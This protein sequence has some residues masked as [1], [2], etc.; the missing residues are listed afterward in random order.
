MVISSISMGPHELWIVS[1]SQLPNK[2]MGLRNDPHICEKRTRNLLKLQQNQGIYRDCLVVACFRL[3]NEGNPTV[4]AG[5]QFSGAGDLPLFGVRVDH[6]FDKHLLFPGN[7]Q[8]ILV[9]IPH[10]VASG[11]GWQFDI[12]ADDVDVL[13]Y[14]TEGVVKYTVCLK[15]ERME[16][17]ELREPLLD[18]FQFKQRL[19]TGE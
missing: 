4:L 8:E 19:A 18:S 6:D 1:E 9:M 7:C 13:N 16:P 2:L 3:Q 12:H 14:S 17:M 5:N 15:I 10:G 11:R